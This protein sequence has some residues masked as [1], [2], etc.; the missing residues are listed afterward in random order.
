[1]KG[2]T[3]TQ[4]PSQAAQF[5]KL[6]GLVLI[7]FTL[8]NYLLLL[9]PL[10]L[11]DVQWRLS[12][13][14]QMV[15]L[16]IWPILG[17]GLM[18]AAY[19]FEEILGQSKALP[20]IGWKTLKFWVYLVSLLLGIIFLLLIPLHITSAVGASNDTVKQIEQ[21][22]TQ[23]KQE[24]EQ[25][26]ENQQAQ[27]TSLLA[28]NQGLEDFTK[29]SELSE[30]QLA[31]LEQFKNDPA[32]LK[33]QTETIRDRLTQRIDRRKEEAE[34]RSQMGAFKSSIR[35]GISSLL[36]ASCY[37]TIGWSGFRGNRPRRAR[38]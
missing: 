18:F 26:L 30:D 19:A 14:T 17:I 13:T 12:F 25:R 6:G 3:V 24:L 22:A 8:F 33:L 34:K 1:M 16:G 35:I 21:E 2:T 27:M 31:R 23:A 20:T 11:F 15:D 10:N 32:A 36:L 28:D 4:I 29:N 9:F 38:R 37:L 7:I 5:L